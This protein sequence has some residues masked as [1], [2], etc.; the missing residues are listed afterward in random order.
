MIVD[1]HAQ[2]E[3]DEPEPEEEDQNENQRYSSNEEEDTCNQLVLFEPTGLDTEMMLLQQ[4]TLDAPTL[5]PTSVAQLIS[6][7][8]IAARISLRASALFLEAVLESAQ[9]TTDASMGIT[10]R[11]LIAAAQSA[12]MVHSIRDG[13]VHDKLNSDK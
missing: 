9:C 10:R 13:S 8:S 12:R 7:A 4:N 3:L 5:L 2:V 1:S 6:A 11:A